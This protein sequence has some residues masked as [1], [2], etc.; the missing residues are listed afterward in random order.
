MN[1][2]TLTLSIDETNTVLQGLGAMPFSEVHQLIAKIQQQANQQ[3]QPGENGSAAAKS[4]AGAK[5]KK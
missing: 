1:E 4:G 3:L 2:I 5:S